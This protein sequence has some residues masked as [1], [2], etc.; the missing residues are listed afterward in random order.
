MTG[1]IREKYREHGLFGLCKSIA[2]KLGR[3]IFETNEAFWWER[4]LSEPITDIQPRIPVEFDLYGA[5]ETIGWIKKRKE[6]W[7]YNPREL[8]VGLEEGHFFPNL[9]Y[10]GKIIGYA[11][12]GRGR[13]YISDYKKVIQLPEDTAIC[14]DY[15]ILPEFQGKFLSDFVM[16]ENLKLARRLGFKKTQG[17]IP[18]WNVAAIRVVR[19]LGF[20]KFKYVRSFRIFGI[21]TYCYQRKINH[22]KS[23]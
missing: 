14:Y 8:R 23:N 1:K 12:L 4:D 3:Y 5:Q 7:I 22:E 10:Q 16:S 18:P 6:S 2:L 19:K 15:H 17:N 11:K 13:V 20:K 21:I 9:K